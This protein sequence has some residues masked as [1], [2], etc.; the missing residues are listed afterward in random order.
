MKEIRA[1][2][3]GMVGI[4]HS[5]PHSDAYPS[6]HDVKLAFYPEASYIIIS[7]KDRDGSRIRSFKIIDGEITEEELKIIWV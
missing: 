3:L 4:Y 2:N 5:H 6:A 1:E 7:L